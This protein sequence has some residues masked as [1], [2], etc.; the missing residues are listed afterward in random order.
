MCT[1]F[2]RI[3]AVSE[4]KNR[5]I[6]FAALNWGSGHVS[7]S[8]PLL[9]TLEQQNNSII[10]ACNLHQEH[11]FRC[12]LDKAKYILLDDYPFVFSTSGFSIKDLIFGF[13]QLFKQLLK[14]QR[15]VAELVNIE[16]INLVL[17]DHR[18]GF[19][20]ANVE[21]IFITHQCMLPIPWYGL[22]F[23]GVH[24]FLMHRFQACWIADCEKLR[25]AGKLSARPNIPFKYLGILS[26]LQKSERKKKWK[27]LLL[28]GPKE[29]HPLLIASFKT[30]LDK[31]D[32]V[33]GSHP[34]LSNSI[35]QITAWDE[36]DKILASAKTVMSFCGYSTLMDME[37]LQCEW[38]S[39][40][41]PGQFE[42]QYLHQQKTLR[43]GGFR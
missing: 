37:T 28:N 19:I 4:I 15:K 30:E 17:S 24:R 22:P 26:R 33:I 8:I 25:L 34:S 3:P 31:L 23:Q 9:Q 1:N 29:F 38:L 5:R 13:P 7:R 35:P 10:V 14:E 39:I 11:I 20:H 12:Y 43:E 21:S 27:V 16:A 41:T 36:A 2:N 18:Y 42:Q 6:L 40:P 32:F